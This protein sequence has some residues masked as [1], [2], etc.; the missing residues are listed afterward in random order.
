MAP[1]AESVTFWLGIVI[2]VVIF[3]GGLFGYD[4]GVIS[5]ALPGI[6]A[7]FSLSVFMLQVVTSWV[8][9]G[10]LA[11]SLI[12]GS[13]GDAIGRKR[14]MLLAGALFTLG[15]A[16]QSLAPGELVLVMGRLVI[17]IGVG[18]AAVAAPLY[19]AELAP[20]SLRGRFISSY[21]L[22]ITIGIFLAYVVN[23][24]LSASGNWRIMLGAAAV[25]GLA[26]FIAALVTSESPR[27][28]IMKNRRDEAREEEHKVNPRIDVEAYLDSVELS[29]RTEE[30]PAPWS[31]IFH[32][33]WRH[34]LLVAIGLAIFQ[35]ITGIN[36]IIYYANQIFA[37]AGFV[38]AESQAIV[39][40]W[41]IGGVNVLATFI[42]VAFIDNEGRR[43]LLLTGLVGMGVSLIVV[44]FAFRFIGAEGQ[45][46]G[47]AGPTLAGIVTVAALIL[48]I[49]CFA[50]SLGPVTWTVINEVFP[51]RVRGRG[52]ALATAINWGSA[53]LVSQF[54]LSL[55]EAIGSSLTFWLF[56]FFCAVAWIWIYRA[57]PETK[58]QSLEDIQRMW[59]SQA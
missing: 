39:T 4:Q 46:A 36:A 6:K 34:P 51:A 28:L 19:A 11:G 52:V 53:Y 20:A 18:V 2:V 1:A 49:A 21:Q 26:L 55:V 40:T 56:G 23:A 41:A 5:G 14:T 31:E 43:K 10:A 8:T 3:A 42:A 17:G 15:A 33:E 30:K 7:S 25:P 44:G 50:F 54:F 32:R 45:A 38:S 58:R 16:V 9:L 12:A 13:L 35:Q 29:L 48:F 24:H 47:L 27:W 59:A 22:A 37:S 57:V